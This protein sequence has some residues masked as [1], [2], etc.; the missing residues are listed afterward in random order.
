MSASQCTDIVSCDVLQTCS[1][2]GSEV[3]ASSSKADLVR[4]TSYA[5]D[6]AST[7]APEEDLVRTSSGSDIT[8][9]AEPASLTCS[10]NH[11]FAAPHVKNVTIIR[12]VSAHGQNSDP[13]VAGLLRQLRELSDVVFHED[14]LVEVTKRSPWRLFL[15]ASEDLAV[16]CGFITFRVMNGRLSIAKTAVPL[17][18][19]GLGFGRHLLENVMKTA[20]TQSDVYEVILSSLSTAVTFYQRCG[21]KA[22]K[23]VKSGEE[24]VVEG[25]VYMV[26]KLK[27][28]PRRTKK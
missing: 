11:A 23:G 7:A 26:K 2:S 21:F 8:S 20:K 15:L 28:P 1:D 22:M 6:I 18:F 16:L 13:R 9:T 27:A 3:D 25:Q 19:R 24:D 17:E 14:C 5:S 4:T 10:P 12:N